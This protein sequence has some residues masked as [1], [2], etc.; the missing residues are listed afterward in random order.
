M[1]EQ[2]RTR[3]KQALFKVVLDLYSLPGFGEIRSQV[4]KLVALYR[5]EVKRNEISDAPDPLKILPYLRRMANIGIRLNDLVKSYKQKL[6]EVAD[7]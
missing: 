4:G 7:D 3:N 1:I 5:H 2:V 6:V